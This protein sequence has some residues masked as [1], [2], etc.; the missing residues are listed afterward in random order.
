[1]SPVFVIPGKGRGDRLEPFTIWVTL[2]GH[3]QIASA[4]DG[5]RFLEYLGGAVAE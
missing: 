2:G 3:R 4:I 5:E 1:M